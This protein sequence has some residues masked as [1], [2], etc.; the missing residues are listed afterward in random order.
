MKISVIWAWS[1]WLALSDVLAYNGNDVLVYAKEP[2]SAEEIN[3]KHTSE[4]YLDGKKIDKKIRACDNLKEALDFSNYLLIAVPS[5]FISSVLEEI[6]D[7]K[8]SDDYFF[9]SAT[10]WLASNKTIQQ[11]I[12]EYFPKHRWLVSVLW[13][14][15]AK[16]V[17]DKN[18][19][20]I[21][22]VSEDKKE[23]LFVQALFSNDYFRLYTQTDV[24][25]AEIYSSMKNALAIASWIITWLWYENNTK[26]SLITRW[27]K[28]MALIGDTL[29]AKKETFFWLTWLGDLILTCSS[30]ESR[31]FQAWYQIWK[32]NSAKRFLKNNKT[33]VEWL[34]TIWVIEEIAKKYEL[35]LPILHALY[36]VVYENAKPSEMLKQIMQRPLTKEHNIQK[37]K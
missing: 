12:N 36:L 28:E 33:T 35:E 31:N 14:S 32:D 8:P 9:I 29:G 22:S 2:N 27:L 19:T 7:I 21:C 25:G 24:I 3:K 1:R 6:K 17:I 26:A 10:K 23:A 4:K 37:I 18:I 15:F 16:E 34:A 5:K 13:P 11:I 20:C 30:D